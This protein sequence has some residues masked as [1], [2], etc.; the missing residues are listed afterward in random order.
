MSPLFGNNYAGVIPNLYN[1]MLVEYYIMAINSEG[2]VENYPSNAPENT[3]IFTIGD[4]PDYYFTDFE[5]NS[6]GWVVGEQFV[7]DASAGIWELAIPV[8]TFDDEGQSSSAWG[9]CN[10]KW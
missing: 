3:I 7:D 2:I 4:L 8:A 10:Y 9:R 6:D 1:G 5:S